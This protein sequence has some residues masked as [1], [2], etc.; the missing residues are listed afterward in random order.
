MPASEQEEDD[1]EDGLPSPPLDEAAFFT[2][3][4]TSM[5]LSQVC[6]YFRVE[7]SLY[8]QEKLSTLCCIGGF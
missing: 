3:Q 2:T 6:L 8:S 1:Y 7:L 4:P 5:E